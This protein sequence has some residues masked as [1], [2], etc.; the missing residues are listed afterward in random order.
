[1]P[2]EGVLSYY[3]IEPI[4][5]ARKKNYADAAISL[6]LGRTKMR[7]EIKTDHILLP[8][9]AHLP[10]TLLQSVMDNP[11]SCFEIQADG[12]VKIETYSEYTGRYYTLFPTER[13]PTMLLSG[14]PMH[15]IK[16]IDPYADTLAKIRAAQPAGLVLDTTTGLGYT[17]IQAALKA[18]HVTTIELDPAVLEICRRNPWS[19]ELFGNPNI[20]QL[21]GDSYE[22]IQTFQDGRFSCV[23]HDP[24][25][26]SLAGELYSFE[27]YKQVYRIL[28]PNGR[29]FHYIG[30]LQSPSGK[31]VLRG[32]TQRLT[33]ANFKRIVLHP[34][35]FALLAYKH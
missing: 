29:I 20:T 14:I 17:A 10:W 11:Q 19:Q 23:I 32:A 2:L 28:K 5:Q 27:F 9:G 26:F 13:A 6:D 4:F 8:D 12:L 7:V 34:E 31:R 33:K 22:V 16:N 35:A 3:A 15:R 24:P 1:M 18:K 25:T 30:D 21:I